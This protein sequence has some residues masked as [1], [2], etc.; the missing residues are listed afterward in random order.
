MLLKER[1][2]EKINEKQSTHFEPINAHNRVY[3]RYV[4]PRIVHRIRVAVKIE[5]EFNELDSLNMCA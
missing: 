1:K 3:V 4:R 5:C 2:K